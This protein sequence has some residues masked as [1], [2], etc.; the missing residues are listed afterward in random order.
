MTTA[1]IRRDFLIDRLFRPGEME[2]VYTDLDRLVVGGAIPDGELQL[3]TYPELGTRYFTERRELG[4]INL[5]QAGEIAV[6][7]SLFQV[8]HLDCLYIGTGEPQV[9]FR[10]HP[11]REAA[12]YMLSAPAH[13]K[14]PTTLLTRSEATAKE[15]GAAEHASKRKLVQYIHEGGIESC[16]LVMG[17]TALEP[18]SVWNTWPPHTHLRRSEIY[19]YFGLQGGAAM[20]FLGE[21]AAS[22]HVVVREREA[23]LSPPWSVHTGVGTGAYSFVWGMAGENR[24]FEDMDP[25]DV[26]KFA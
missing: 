21:A 2:M 7:D 1:E 14:F 15:I 18:G 17:Y 24:S 26:A 22:K 3:P 20:H 19:L 6:G 9:T 11:G 25:V 23:V 10:N 13:R 8:G 4:I 12:F 16:Q 5:G